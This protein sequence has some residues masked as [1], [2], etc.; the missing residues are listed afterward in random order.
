V[1]TSQNVCEYINFLFYFILKNIDNDE[2]FSHTYTP[3]L[4]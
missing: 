4:G 1:I 2:V 3:T